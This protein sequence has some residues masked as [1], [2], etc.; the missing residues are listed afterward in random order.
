MADLYNNPM[1]HMHGW[2]VQ[3]RMDMWSYP[4]LEIFCPHGIGHP[5]PE[6]VHMLNKIEPKAKR[7]WSAHGCDGCCLARKDAV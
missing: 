1:S 4:L 6:S 7:D 5:M 3:R 2:T